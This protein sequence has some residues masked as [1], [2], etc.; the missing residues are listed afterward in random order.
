LHASQAGTEEARARLRGEPTNSNYA[1]D[2]AENP[3][4]DYDT[5]QYAIYLYNAA[6]LIQVRE[7]GYS[8]GDFGS[9]QMG[10]RFAVE[11]VGSTIV[12]KKNGDIFHTSGTPTDSALF[13]DCAIHTDGGEISDVKLSA[14]DISYWVKIRHKREADMLPNEP[15]VD[16]GS[17]SNDIIYYGYATSTSTT[18]E[19]FTTTDANPVTGSPVEI[20]TSY[21]SSGA[22]S[23]IIEIQTRTVPGPPIL[24]SVYGDTVAGGGD[25]TING[26]DD[27][28]SADSVPAVAYVD[29]D[30]NG[31]DDEDLTSA[32]AEG[33]STQIASA[34]D[35]ATIVNELESTATV[36]VTGDQT[37]YS[38]GSSS[39]YEVVY[40]DA[41][42][43]HPDN[44]LDLNNLTGYGTLVVRGDLNLAGNINWNGTIIASGDVSF[45]GGGN[46]E[47]YGAV[48]AAG[49]VNIMGTVDI[50]YDSCEIDNAKG[51]YRYDTF[52]WEDKKLM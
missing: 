7:R 17:T 9:Y 29:A 39:N 52:R 32:A 13:V 1:G 34:I 49:D 23:G 8:Q 41:T 2:P 12:Y 11:R 45:S 14:S 10:D 47:I 18:A 4:P 38:V 31:I 51:S 24:G 42:N 21:G 43:L 33:L 6:G 46:K 19:Q 35:L 3:D 25:I 20:I 44:E 30:G 27:C 40:C 28:A 16:N 36:T 22:S 50:Y 48:L 15:Y 37:N 26:D 5:I